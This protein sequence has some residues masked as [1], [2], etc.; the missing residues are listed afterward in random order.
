MLIMS[1]P[2]ATIRTT[3]MQD[4]FTVASYELVSVVKTMFAYEL[5]YSSTAKSPHPG[6]ITNAL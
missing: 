6:I 5:L 4:S 1:F 2:S 3:T